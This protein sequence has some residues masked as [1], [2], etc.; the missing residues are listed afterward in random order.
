MKIDQTELLYFTLLNQ[1]LLQKVPKMT[2]ISDLCGLQAQFANNPQ[3]AL[4]ARAS[5]FNEAAWGDG[6]VKIWSFRSTLHAV[7]IDE[8][9]LFLSARG[10]PDAWDDS[11]TGLKKEIKPY[12]SEFIQERIAAGICGRE[13]L[14]EACR[15]QGMEPDI[16]EKVFYGWGG[17]IKEMCDRGLIAYEIGT[18]KRFVVCDQLTFTDRGEARAALI[19]RY[20]QN[21]APATIEDCATFTGYKK[22]EV[23]RLIEAYSLPLKAI[24]CE[25]IEYYHSNEL[26]GDGRIPACIFLAGFDQMIMGYKDRRRLLND[27]D[28]SNVVTNSGIV[29]PT[30]LLDGRLRA[31][32]KKDG[33]KLVITPFA[34]LSKLN[35][36]RTIAAGRKLF[37]G[38]IEAVVFEG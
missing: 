29:H 1:H 34:K 28:K 32:W 15:Q 11:W 27:A 8:I 23:L 33:A 2:V 7:R 10:V 6:L 5:D 19:G 24:E 22:R 4:R 21:F 12:W 38:E 20:F 35:R 31:R 18:A 36:N 37:A 30:V 3:Y 25:G 16:L 13:P 14:K 26:S 17:L 9:G